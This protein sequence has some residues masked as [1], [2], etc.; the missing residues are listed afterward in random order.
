MPRRGIDWEAEYNVR[1]RH[2]DRH[3]LHEQCVAQSRAA[4]G[5]MR[6]IRDV[7]CGDGPRALLDF[8]PAEAA[9]STGGPVLA[10]FHGGYW[11]SHERTEYALIARPFVRAGIATAVVG[12]DLTPTQRLGAIVRQARDAC[13]WLRDN[14]DALGFDGRLVFT[15]GH[16]AGAHLA[17][18][19]LTDKASPARGAVLLSGIYDLAP[20]RF[21]SLNESVG[22]DAEQV[23]CLS[24]LMHPLPR[25]G[26][27][28]I[29]VGQR[30]TQEFRRQALRLATKWRSARRGADLMVV[31]RLHHY[32]IVLALGQPGSAL[33]QAAVRRVLQTASAGP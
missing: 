13:R 33:A 8:F 9:C 12:Y 1:L 10:F 14:A 32:D 30:E 11:H 16:S 5:E 29:A 3:A 18:C 31:P 23:R 20:L 19:V 15:A 24:P 28:L 26:D 21:T 7:R 6:C 4:Y 2:P 22:L 27:L 17:V 25:M